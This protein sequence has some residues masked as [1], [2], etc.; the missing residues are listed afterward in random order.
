MP[1]VPLTGSRATSAFRLPSLP[2]ARR[3]SILPL[4]RVAMPAES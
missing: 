1:M 3:R 2:S 4:T